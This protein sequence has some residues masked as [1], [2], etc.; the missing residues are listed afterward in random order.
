MFVPPT[1]LQLYDEDT[2]TADDFIGCC[3]VSLAAV[4]VRRSAHLRVCYTPGV[5]WLGREA[6]TGEQGTTGSTQG[7]THLLSDLLYRI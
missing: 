1:P 2:L 5:V 3:Q 4:G 7:S 6:Y